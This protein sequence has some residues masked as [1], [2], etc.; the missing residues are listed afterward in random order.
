MTTGIS[1]FANVI[2]SYR[3]PTNT[4]GSRIIARSEHTKIT[5]PYDHDLGIAENHRQAAET[6][7]QRLNYPEAA[8]MLSGELPNGDYAHVFFHPS[9]LSRVVAT[10]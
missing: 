5:I 4:K 8:V 9:E 1:Y 3:G 10:A 2:T 6:L 7:R